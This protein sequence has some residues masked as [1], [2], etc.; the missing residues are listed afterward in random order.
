[1]DMSLVKLRELVMDREAWHAAIHGATKS[2]T[3]LSNSTELTG[4]ETIKNTN[5]WRLNNALLNNQQIAEEIKICIETNESENT[6]TQNLWVSKSSARG[7]FIAIQAYFKN[8][9]KVK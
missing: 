8:K 5:R 6:T 1:M 7:R 9:T 4:K 3:Q 2:Q